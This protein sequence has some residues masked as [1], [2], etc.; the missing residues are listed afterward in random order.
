M[1]ACFVFADIIDKFFNQFF[2]ASKL[3]IE[4][5]LALF[6]NLFVDEK[7]GLEVRRAKRRAKRACFRVS[8][9]STL[10]LPYA[11]SLLSAL[12]RF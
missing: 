6:E 3:P 12:T 10:I 7:L 4:K 1:A 9:R 5:D 8:R 2:D 11:T